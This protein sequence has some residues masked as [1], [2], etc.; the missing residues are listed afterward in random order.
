MAAIVSIVLG[1]FSFLLPDTPPQA[2]TPSSAKSILGID[3]LLLFR[4]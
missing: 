2:K 1:L 3:A 4:G